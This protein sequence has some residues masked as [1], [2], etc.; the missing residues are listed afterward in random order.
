MKSSTAKRI[1]IVGGGSGGLK[2][3]TR[4]GRRYRRDEN[5]EV[6]LVDG[7]LTHVWKPLLHEIAAG[8]LDIHEDECN[9][10]AHARR[11]HFRFVWGRMQGL[12]KERRRIELEPLDGNGDGRTVPTRELAFDV[13][14]LAVGGIS[15]D[16]G[17]AGVAEHCFRLDSAAEA[18]RFRR[19]L[20]E[21][22]LRAGQSDTMPAPG[23]LDVAIV[24]GGATGVELA[25]EL[26]K[27]R[28]ELNEYGAVGI[29][30][31]KDTQMTLLERVPRLLPGLP[32]EL[33]ESTEVELSKRGVDVRTGEAVAEVTAEGV[34]TDSGETIPARFSVW[35]AG[36]R[37]QSF[38][39]KLNGLETNHRD[40][41]MV[42]RTLQTT[43][44][45]RIFALG[46]CAACPLGDEAGGFVP[47]RAQA[48]DQQS[49]FLATQL[50]R[51]LAGEALKSY[52][53]RDRGSL[54]SLDDTAV[55]TLMGALLGNVTFEGWAARM[56]YRMLYRSHQR[57]LHGSF[58]AMMLWTS[59]VLG[60]RTR[61]RLKLH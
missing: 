16:F 14:V 38:L 23:E 5:V 28:R 44:D 60:H 10:L 39:A 45:D 58:R 57:A 49:K 42:R 47:P 12:D 43:T 37:G 48:A 59:D 40:Q 2:L 53:Y 1:V 55:G 18:E 46:D 8:T 51:L 21:A 20:L 19:S 36:I 17:I 6:T 24:G 9:Y 34:R 41:V 27:M 11:H 22:Y 13:L 4:L 15:D 25:A 7:T 52:T 30:A 26:D 33:A 29:D 50:P 61:P 54:V 32:E 35:A 31:V 3:A 56:S